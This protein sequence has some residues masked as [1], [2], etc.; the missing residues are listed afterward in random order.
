MENLKHIGIEA[1]IVCES[2]HMSIVQPPG[3][4]RSTSSDTICIA[5]KDVVLELRAYPMPMPGAG[6]EHV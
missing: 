3:A 1:S 4:K 5:K 6:G 2:S